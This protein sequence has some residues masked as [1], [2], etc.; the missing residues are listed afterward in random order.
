MSDLRDRCRGMIVCG[1]YGD[2][3]GYPI[4]FMSMR[5]IERAFGPDGLTG[6]VLTD[7]RM[8]FSDDTQM[9]LLAAD[10]IIR[11]E[12]CRRDNGTADPPYRYAYRSY[13]LWALGM[14]GFYD[15]KGAGPSDPWLLKIPEI[16]SKRA[17]GNT[18]M[19][20][21]LNHAEPGTIETRC[22][23]SKGCGGVMRAAPYS[24]LDDV[25]YSIEMACRDAA[26][27]H[28]HDLG[29]LTAG[30]FA[31][32]L[33]FIIH[34]DRPLKG[35]IDKGLGVME[36]VYG[37]FDHWEEVRNLIADVVR[38][39]DDGRGH[40]ISEIGEGW[41]AEETLAMALYSCL[42][43]GN[44][45]EMALLFSVNHGG[46]SDSVGSVTGNILGAMHGFDGLSGSVDFGG[47][48]RFDVISKV[49]D[50]LSLMDGGSDHRSYAGSSVF[51]LEYT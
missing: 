11:S 40:D 9:T 48:E 38:I 31:G 42:R 4:E 32:I 44:D 30:L 13:R 47:L 27:T 7:G 43:Y 10:S 46:D 1:A 41:I 14:F 18:C 28:G 21:L 22:N 2:A 35:S 8:L 33:W 17:P 26:G 24:M 3:L 34:E 19:R 45:P 15:P 37:R 25:D 23:N 6:P 16:V 5:D 20:Q 50:E 36:T 12:S 29:W 51:S 49:A 39:S